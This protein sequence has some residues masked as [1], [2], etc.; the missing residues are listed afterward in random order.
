MELSRVAEEAQVDRHHENDVE[1]K[2]GH[3]QRAE[4]DPPELH[5]LE[6]EVRIS[7]HEFI[8]RTSEPGDPVEDEAN[9][10]QILREEGDLRS[11]AIQS[12]LELKPALL[13][14]VLVR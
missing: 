3:D 8:R 11:R 4:H 1:P 14:R 6:C 9:G 12:L 10:E 13:A 5:F 7:H 2:T